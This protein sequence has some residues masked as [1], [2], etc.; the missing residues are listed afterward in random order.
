MQKN[1]PNYTPNTHFGVLGCPGGARGGQNLQRGVVGG[2]LHRIENFK[3]SQK[4][5]K[6]YTCKKI[7]QTILP[8]PILGYLDALGG[9]RGVK[10]FRGAP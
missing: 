1:T 9:P 7:P 3:N 6:K 8:T 5:Y 2:F 10:I 4:L